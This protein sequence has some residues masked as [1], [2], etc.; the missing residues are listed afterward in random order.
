M[1]TVLFAG[2]AIVDVRIFHP[3]NSMTNYVLVCQTEPSLSAS[4]VKDNLNAQV[5]VTNVQHNNQLQSVNNLV[6]KFYGFDCVVEGLAV[7]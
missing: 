6:P 5:Y 7:R 1:I 4:T 2:C 3:D